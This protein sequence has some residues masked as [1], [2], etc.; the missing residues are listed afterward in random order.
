MIF[1]ENK[2]WKVVYAWGLLRSQ[3][4]I[5][6]KLTIPTK[7]A[8]FCI[9]LHCRHTKPSKGFIW[10]ETVFLVVVLIPKWIFPKLCAASK[11]FE[12]R[13]PCIVAWIYTHFFVS[14]FYSSNQLFSILAIWGG[15]ESCPSTTAFTFLNRNPNFII[16]IRW[17]GIQHL[18]CLLSCILSSTS[19]HIDIPC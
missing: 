12:N 14:G 17:N 10:V 6:T 16:E 9:I 1:R 2:K 7:I 13:L 18:I 8:P 3:L 19:F 5:E 11:G 4:I 15:W